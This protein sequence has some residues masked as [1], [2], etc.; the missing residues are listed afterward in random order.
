MSYES[1]VARISRLENGFEVE[2]YEK[3]KEQKKGEPYDYV[4]PWKKFAFGTAKE[5][6]AFLQGRIEHLK[7]PDSEYAEGFKE[8]TKTK[9]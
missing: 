1:Q 3:P 6:M 5:M 4:D 7:A 2:V 8:A 9:K